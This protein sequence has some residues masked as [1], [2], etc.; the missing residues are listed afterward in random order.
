MGHPLLGTRTRKSTGN[1]SGCRGGSANS[2]S[3]LSL[4]S[5]VAELPQWPGSGDAALWSVQD[6]TRWASG[7][8]NRGT[9]LQFVSALGL[10]R[11]SRLATFGDGPDGDLNP[12]RLVLRCLDSLKF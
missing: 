1:L 2:S 9:G 7:S 4:R 6:T 5:T 8:R 3:Q 10:A 11:A 12:R